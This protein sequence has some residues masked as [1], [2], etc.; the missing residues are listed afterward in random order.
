M[1]Y[2]GF[3]FSWGP[4]HRIDANIGIMYSWEDLLLYYIMILVVTKSNVHAYLTRVLLKY[5]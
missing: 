5:S 1:G 3:K 4:K 2:L